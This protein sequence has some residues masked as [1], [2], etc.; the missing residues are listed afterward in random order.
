[1]FI[2]FAQFLTLSGAAGLARA[3]GT[4]AWQRPCQPEKDPDGP[5]WPLSCPPQPPRPTRS[6]PGPGWA[7]RPGGPGLRR[8]RLRRRGAPGAA[9]DPAEPGR[10]GRPGLRYVCLRRSGAPRHASAATVHPV[11]PGA[12]PC[13]PGR[14]G[15]LRR[16]GALRRGRLRRR[17]APG[18][19]RGPGWAGP[20]GVAVSS[21]ALPI[22]MPA[23]S[24]LYQRLIASVGTRLAGQA[25]NL[26][27]PQLPIGAVDSF[28]RQAL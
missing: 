21:E 12:R 17:G 14:H 27:V 6:R 28:G 4:R 20:A 16:R 24:Q 11:P 10:A 25:G 3:G 9:R 15:R 5:A 18:A 8:G 7:G 22:S 26:P 2:V 23:H 13:R 1:M 19:A